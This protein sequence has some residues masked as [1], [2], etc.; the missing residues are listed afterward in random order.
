MAAIGAMLAL[1]VQATPPSVPPPAAQTPPAQQP[2]PP[3]QPPVFRSGAELVRVDVTVLD[4]KGQPVRDLR[5]EDFE[6]RE[7]GVEQ[8]IRSFDL[9]DL[10]PPAAADGRNLEITSRYHAEQELAREDVRTFLI[11]WDEY[12]I[13]PD[14]RSQIL[15]DAMVKFLRT[16]VA[17]TDLVAIMDPWTPMTHLAWTRDRAKLWN[18]ALGLKGRQGVYLP[19]RNGAEEEHLREGRMPQL[20]AQVALSAL[21]SAMRHLGTLR[22]GRKAVIYFSREFSLG[23]R[24]DDFNE[25]LDLIRTANDANVALYVVS[26]DGIQMRG[27]GGGILTDLARESG[28]EATVTND[29]GVALRRAAE[30]TGAVYLLGYAPE[31]LRRD[32]KFH[33]IKVE[34]KRSGLQVRARNGYWSPDEKTMAAAKSASA[35]AV[36]PTAIESAIGELARLD[37]HDGDTPLALPSVIEPAEPSAVLSAQLPRLWVVRRPADLRDV[38]GEAPPDPTPQREFSRTDRLI[39]RLD[40]AGSEAGKAQVTA[41]LVDRRGKRLVDLP[42]KP[43]GS[44][45]MLDL[46]LSSIA[47]GDYV[48]ALEA[49][50]GETRAAAYVPVR[51]KP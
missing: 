30:Q 12:H 38:L 41:G 8:R 35:A 26:P 22:E 13:P 51:V 36:V 21:A 18:T 25:T 31:P 29:P 33:K 15:R 39:L 17:P 4:R 16:M 34:V 28:G 40:L 43:E 50:A 48:I 27:I 10:A 37:W 49:R 44:G 7:D 11:Y 23:R 6:L 32:G 42:V 9:L 20:R 3:Q 47:R 24:S 46:P 45:W 1:A 2:Q 14:F 5:A 19:P